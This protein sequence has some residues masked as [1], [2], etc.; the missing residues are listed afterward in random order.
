MSYLNIQD[1]KLIPVVVELNTLLA[2]YHVYY[3]KLRN[4]HWNRLGENF[5]DL[6]NKLEEL[7]TDARSKIDGIAEH[8]LTLRHHP[9]SKLSD[10]LDISKVKESSPLQSDMSMVTELIKDHNI[11]LDQMSKVL[12]KANVAKDK[13]TIDLINI[14]IKE[15]ET[16]SMM[17]N[18]WAKKS[19]EN[20]ERS[21]VE[22]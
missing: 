6:H 4:F 12:I 11:L 15:L 3:Q 14:Y 10:Y 2:N 13:D 8:I 21:V 17:L 7:Y 18:D 20:S 19:A 22:A 9:M 5:F 1:D 16:D